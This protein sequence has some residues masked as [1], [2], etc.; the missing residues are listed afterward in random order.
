MGT[1]DY[2]DDFYRDRVASRKATGTPTFI[3]DAAVRS[4]KVKAG[5]HDSLNIRGKIRESRDSKQHPNST[6]IGIVFD[7][8]GSM[9]KVP[10][11]MQE[12]LPQFMGLL[13]RKAWIEDPQ[14]L[15]GAI[16]DYPNHEAAP[17]QIGQFESGIEM[18]DNITHIYLEGNGGGSHQESYQNALYFFA[19]RTRCDAFEKRGK[20]GYLFIIGDEMAYMR[21][22]KAELDALIGDGA[23]D[24]ASLDDIMAAVK[25]KWEVFFLLPKGTQHWADPRIEAFW[26]KYLG[27][28]FIRLED[29]NAVCE[30]IGALI[31]ICEGTATGDSLAADMKDIGAHDAIVRVATASVD[32]IAKD[33]A[34][35]RVGT[36]GSL[37]GKTG[38][39]EKIERL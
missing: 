16:G 7:Q 33:R 39:S 6:P 15:F 3:H 36:G 38:R 11:L 20:K 27:Q 32:A 12:K 23:Q 18:D 5:V 22:T 19:H 14:V 2:S 17:L 34:L 37:P 25:E 21:S 28:N 4:G 31:G 24:D 8:T 13:L 10:G 29:P 30:V 9:D 26:K 35:A 1:N